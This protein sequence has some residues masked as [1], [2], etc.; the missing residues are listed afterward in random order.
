MPIVLPP[1][2]KVRLWPFVPG[3]FKNMDSTAW[4]GTLVAKI[5]VRKRL[6]NVSEPKPME[7]VLITNRMLRFGSTYLNPYDQFGL[8]ADIDQ[9]RPLKRK[10]SLAGLSPP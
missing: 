1:P 4:Q 8:T 7:R 2:R 3:R 6:Q 9:I 10:T 5:I